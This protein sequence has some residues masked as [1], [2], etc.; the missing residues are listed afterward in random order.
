MRDMVKPT[1]SLFIICLVVSFLLAFVNGI[2]KDTIVQRA[3]ADAKEQRKLALSEASNF[4]KIDGWEGKDKS[5]LIREAYAA[6]SGDNLIGYV[7]SASPKGYGGEIAVTVG[8]SREKK[9]SGVKVGGNSETPGLGS[10]TAND[11]FTG[12]YKDKDVK[13]DF[14][15]VKRPATV[16]NEI[17]AVSGATIS[18]AAVTKAVKASAELGSILLQEQN[19]GEVK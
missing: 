6:Y 12:Q 11:D 16:D 14:I 4:K 10:K 3:A 15:V 2:T 18:S 13:K 8:I 17:Q 19:G 5:G 7:F 9:V 1:L